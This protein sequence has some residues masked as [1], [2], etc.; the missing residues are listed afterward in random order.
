MKGGA[1]YHVSM[2]QGHSLYFLY[3][4]ELNSTFRI[5]E[6]IT[7]G[8]LYSYATPLH[9]ITLHEVLKSQ[10]FLFGSDS[11]YEDLQVEVNSSGFCYDCYY[12][13]KLVGAPSAEV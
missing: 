11:P 2:S 12:L 8:S 4:H 1:T 10:H 5:Y 7:S 3:F 6:I 13:I 9:N